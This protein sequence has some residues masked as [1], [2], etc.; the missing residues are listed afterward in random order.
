MKKE[1]YL[2]KIADMKDPSC[3]S[4]PPGTLQKWFCIQTIENNWNYEQCFTKGMQRGFTPKQILQALKKMTT[5]PDSVEAAFRQGMFEGI[6]PFPKWM[7]RTAWYDYT[8]T[9]SMM[10]K[11]YTSRSSMN[12]WIDKYF[13]DAKY[14]I[15][16]NYKVKNMVTSEF[17]RFVRNPPRK[18]LITRWLELFNTYDTEDF[19]VRK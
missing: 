6:I 2:E 13:L 11:D 12:W 14:Y 15:K 18:P 9:C 16:P 7:I 8:D 17:Q 3:T 10:G 19:A 4:Y 1:S 5:V